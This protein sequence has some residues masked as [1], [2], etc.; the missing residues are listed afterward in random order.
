MLR[1]YKEWF[2]KVRE[3]IY[4]WKYVKHF[5]LIYNYYFTFSLF[6]DH[7]VFMGLKFCKP[8]IKNEYLRRSGKMCDHYLKASPYLKTVTTIVYQFLSRK[9]L[10]WYIISIMANILLKRKSKVFNFR[11][12]VRFIRVFAISGS[13][14]VN[15]MG[16]LRDMSVI[17]VRLV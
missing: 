1:Y 16:C 9:I 14:F 13:E 8:P 6:I 12:I 15:P 3:I 11:I 7:V 10:H 5:T 2:F 4:K 17:I